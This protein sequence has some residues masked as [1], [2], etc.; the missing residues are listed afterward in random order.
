[1]SDTVCKII[2]ADPNTK[3]APDKM[4]ATMGNAF[5]MAERFNEILEGLQEK[6]CLSW[7]M[8]L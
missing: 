2:P 5:F 4:D 7:K 6:N 3:I 8:V 1:M